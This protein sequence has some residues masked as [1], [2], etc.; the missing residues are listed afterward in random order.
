MLAGF[1]ACLR[2]STYRLGA[3]CHLH[4][5]R[6][7]V[8]YDECQCGAHRH[9]V[10][11]SMLYAL[12]VLSFF[13]HHFF[14]VCFLFFAMLQFCFT[15]FVVNEKPIWKIGNS[16][17][18][19]GG[20]FC[21]VITKKLGLVRRTGG[22]SHLFFILVFVRNCSTFRNEITNSV[23][24]PAISLYCTNVIESISPVC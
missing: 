18:M 11:N 20:E 4:L 3:N 7:H 16:R 21:A 12:L 8:G 17:D 10:T 24:S 9:R 14:F 15:S 1:S 19:P 5:A 2:T 6:L 13:A 22:I 23:L